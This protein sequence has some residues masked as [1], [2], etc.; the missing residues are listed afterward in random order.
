MLR[1]S[2][3]DRIPRTT[4]R[5]LTLAVLLFAGLLL[6]GALKVSA[7]AEEASDT[8]TPEILVDL[9]RVGN[10]AVHPEGHLIVYTLTVSRASRDEP[11]GS[12]RELWTADLDKGTTRRFTRGGE[13]VGPPAF[14]PD[15][16]RIA[17]VVQRD[18]DDHAQIYTQRVKGGEARA[19]TDHEAS[20][21]T[22]RFSPDG[23]QIAFLAR[24]PESKAEKKAR[25]A[26]DDVKIVDR[27]EKLSRLYLAD[28][29]G[30]K[31]RR[32]IPGDLHVLDLAWAP[33]G[34]TI[35][36]RAAPTTRVDADYMDSRLYAVDVATGDARQVAETPGKLGDFAVSPDGRHVAFLG[37][38][39]RNDP[40]AQSL[41][42][43]PTDGGTP[44]NLTEG[45]EGSAVHLAWWDSDRV[46]LLAVEGTEHALYR[47][48]IESGERERLA[49]PGVAVSAFDLRPDLDLLALA[50]H[51]HAHPP[52]LFVARADASEVRRIDEHN[53]VLAD[54]RLAR[55][56]VVRWHAA[57]G[58]EIEGILTY[59]LGSPENGGESPPHP[60]VLQIHGGPEGVSLNGWTTTPLYPVQLLAK[61]GFAVL[62]PNYR[63]SQGRGVAYSQADHDDLGGSE[64]DDVLA[65]VDDLAERGVID[66]E[67]VGTGGWSYGG[68][69][70]AWA[71]TRHSERFRAA[72][73]GAGITNWISFTGTTDIPYE[74]SLVHWDSWWFDEPELHWQ[75]SPL[76]HLENADTPTLILHGEEDARVHPEQGLELYNALRIKGI[77]TE[78]ALYPR[79]GHGLSER[80][81][82][83]DAIE[84][85]LGWFER[86]LSVPEVGGVKGPRN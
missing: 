79:E 20:V 19:L 64:F 54:L 81:H 5:V 66:P 80:A 59:P 65:G 38:V 63:G 33:G 78:L 1:V 26:G 71:A 56:E 24:D 9:E 4:A 67:R 83:L 10:V 72:M 39:S 29:K 77:D 69:F 12:Y 32:L 52:A 11:G 28:G 25:K 82:Q 2:S 48:A 70:S 31:T 58:T 61:A 15:G 40:L 45:Y 60:L 6:P 27:N 21:G 36:V 43:V 84:R 62:E 41:F 68:Y 86:Y 49:D 35:V 76:A 16:K 17:F 85:V 57:D 22:F 14:T 74:M 42:V 34:E 75:R 18:G 47:L 37:A 13:R 73:V 51:T 7:A 30:K 44:R 50:G 55:Q 46:F 53:P 8:L 23:E 3:L